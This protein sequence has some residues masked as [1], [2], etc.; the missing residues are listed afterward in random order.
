MESNNSMPDSGVSVEPPT[1]HN[2]A[3]QIPPRLV[4]HKKLIIVVGVII[5][6]AL[7]VASWLLFS[8]PHKKIVSQ[9][10]SPSTASKN[11]D[12]PI[13]NAATS[14]MTTGAKNETNLTN[15]DDSNDADSSTNSAA[16]IG[17]SINENNL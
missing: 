10:D 1:V 3:E 11:T 6:T 7:L 2:E 15:T 14:T 17:D 5:I 13:I 16:T 9:S 12:N 8:P 4:S